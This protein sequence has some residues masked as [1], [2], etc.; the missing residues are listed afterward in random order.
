MNLVDQTAANQ[1]IQANTLASTTE[2]YPF[3]ASAFDLLCDYAC[4]DVV[5]STPRN[6]IKTI[7]E[8]AI[9]AWDVQKQVIDDEIV[10]E[11]API[12]FG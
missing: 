12:V 1:K 5:K 8:C 7:N 9:A 4:Q 6:I 10:N 11:I 2:T 3:T